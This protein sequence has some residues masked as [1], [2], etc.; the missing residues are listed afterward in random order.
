MGESAFLWMENTVMA[1]SLEGAAEENRAGLFLELSLAGASTV[2]LSC[3]DMANLKEYF[4]F[5]P[6]DLQPAVIQWQP[7]PVPSVPAHSPQ[8]PHNSPGKGSS[9]GTQSLLAGSC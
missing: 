7:L 2:L 5:K 4:M 3:I 1:H 8:L 6:A 9:D